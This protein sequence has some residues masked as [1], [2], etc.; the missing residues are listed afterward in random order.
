M[1]RTVPVL[2]RFWRKIAVAGPHDCWEWMGTRDHLG[3]GKFS[4]GGARKYGGREVKAHAF[5]YEVIVGPIPE[6]LTIDHLCRNPGCVNPAHLEAVTHGE[7]MRRGN[8]F[9]GLNFRKTHCD[10]G[11]A[12][13]RVNTRIKVDTR[14][15]VHRACRNCQ[16]EDQRSRRAKVAG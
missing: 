5:A 11:H 8:G 3:Y 14:G 1:R 7:N 16:R 13:D 9:S 12:F 10:R 4:I 6:G 2:D 15:R